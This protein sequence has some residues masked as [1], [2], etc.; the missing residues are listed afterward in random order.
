MTYVL[1]LRLSSPE[2]R[3]V[4]ALVSGL[5]RGEAEVITSIFADLDGFKI[6]DRLEEPSVPTR[7]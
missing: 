7:K 4:Q 1:Y 2:G 6:V 5:D 3:S